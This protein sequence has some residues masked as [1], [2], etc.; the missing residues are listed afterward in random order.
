MTLTKVRYRRYEG[1]E[2]GH[3]LAWPS[4]NRKVYYAHA[5]CL[6]GQPEEAQELARIRLRFCGGKIVNPAEYNGHPE[7]VQDGVKF[8][9]K[10]VARCGVIVFSRLLGKVTAGVGKEVNHALSIGKP[11]FELR[12]GEFRPRRRPVQYLTRAQTK[13][14]YKVWR[15]KPAR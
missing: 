6:Y 15:A 4:T 13:R 11:V 3:S 2:G 12:P 10:L 7:K 14:L 9:L 1:K 5:M 8:C